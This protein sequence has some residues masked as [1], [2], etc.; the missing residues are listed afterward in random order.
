MEAQE[1]LKKAMSNRQPISF[2]YRRIGN[3][4]EEKV[5][6]ARVIFLSTDHLGR[7]SVTVDLM[8]EKRISKMRY[9]DL[10]SISNVQIL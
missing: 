9:F 4:R 5:D 2:K 6:I 10:E 8:Q 1:V 3:S 7:D